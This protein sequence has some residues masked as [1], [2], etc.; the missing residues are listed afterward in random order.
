MDGGRVEPALGAPAADPRDGT[1]P[2]GAADGTLPPSTIPGPAPRLG[3]SRRSSS[4]SLGARG[5]SAS[6]PPPA[7]PH[8]GKQTVPSRR[9]DDAAQMPPST[10]AAAADSCTAGPDTKLRPPTRASQACCPR[11]GGALQWRCLC[12]CIMSTRRPPCLLS[13]SAAHPRPRVC[14]TCTWRLAPRL[15][16]C[17]CT[18]S[19]LPACLPACRDDKPAAHALSPMLKSPPWPQC[20]PRA[21]PHR[22]PPAS[23]RCRCSRCGPLPQTLAAPLHAPCMA[24]ARR[25]RTTTCRMAAARPTRTSTAAARQ[26]REQQSKRACAA[27]RHYAPPTKRCASTSR[28]THLYIAA[29]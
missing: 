29:D 19:T 18:L 28:L 17:A 14:S 3:L 27:W 7:M 12:P 4:G 11:M 6:P 24:Q 8:P 2:V 9:E 21:A 25:T 22:C 23:S 16:L 10:A 15:H 13:W 20:S 26:V 5:R 1:A